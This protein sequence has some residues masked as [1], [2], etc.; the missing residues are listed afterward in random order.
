M[1]RPAATVDEVLFVYGSLLD[2]AHRASLLG[3]EVTGLPARLEGYA[4]MRGRYFYIVECVGSFT[5]GLVLTGLN[6]RD[7][8]VLDRYEDAP[9]LYTRARVEVTSAGD[10]M[11]RCWVYLPTAKLLA[12][13]S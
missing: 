5:D 12:S 4:R 13:A 7:F 8:A 1:S 10:K 2:A 6:E 9:R 11:L 3:R